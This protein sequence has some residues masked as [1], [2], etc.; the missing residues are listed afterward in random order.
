MITYETNYLAHHGILGMKWGVRRYQNKDGS[1]T[2][3]GRRRSGTKE[4]KKSKHR[5]NL[6]QKYMSQ[7]YSRETAEKMANN[8][9][10]LEK[11]LAVIGG[12]TLAG[13]AT[14]AAYK[15]GKNI[16]RKKIN[17]NGTVISVGESLHRISIT[18][19]SSGDHDFYA[20]PGRDKMDVRKYKG[21]LG[22]QRT[23]GN[24][25]AYKSKIDVVKD[26][27][28][29]SQKEAE[30]TF[31]KL[32]DTD[33][34]FRALADKTIRSREIKDKWLALRGITY[35]KQTMYE[36]FNRSFV[37]HED[38]DVVS[39]HKRFFDALKSKGFG[40][41]LDV[42][43]QKFS[44]YNAKAPVVV[45]DKDAVSRGVA[46][47]LGIG[48]IAGNMAI[49]RLAERGHTL[50]IGGGLL[51]TAVAVKKYSNTNEDLIKEDKKKKRR[52]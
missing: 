26:I 28:V 44:G 47:K 38:P 27:K 18:D 12:V 33:E 13:V 52:K 43:D 7:G 17:E 1:L 40:A 42:N 46:S 16:A 19:K 14:V 51:G 2:P 4:R 11:T 22:Y 45:F 50:A 41:V 6:E 37:D 29:P 8:R 21:L 5:T 24:G 25:V 10:R 9:I 49:D 3:E 30:N 20:V 48:N 39:A 36:K 32:Y 23:M 35:P 15:I 31:K 34:S